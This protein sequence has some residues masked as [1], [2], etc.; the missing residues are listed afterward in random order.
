MDLI[1]EII[2]TMHDTGVAEGR[3]GKVH[4]LHS[5][6]DREE[7][8]FLYN[9]IKDDPTILRTLEV[10]CA[11]G[12]SSLYICAALQ[13]RTGVSHTI[14]D[15]I[16]NSF[17]DGVGI[18]KLEEAG[19]SFFEFI[20]DYSEFALPRLLRQKDGCFDFIFVDGMHTFDHAL[21]DCFYA[22]RLLRVGGYLMLDDIYF[23]SVRRVVSFISNYPCYEIV[24]SLR[25]PKEA[26][27]SWRSWKKIVG[28][29]VSTLMSPVPRTTWAKVLSPRLHRFLF[30]DQI[31]RMVALR[32]VSEDTRRW[33]WHDDAF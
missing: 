29:S 23:L 4:E 22:T 10:G 14:I 16:E 11:Y 24:G 12:F 13:G 17:W 30:E 3:S 27:F 2:Q 28:R 26:F 5:G 9:I 25:T 8:E 31:T 32:K 6:L 21:L 18:N 33:G 20:E 19:I 1:D 15:P 7:G